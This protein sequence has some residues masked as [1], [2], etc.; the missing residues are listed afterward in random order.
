MSDCIFCKIVK[1]EA[2]SRKV[3]ETEDTYAFF[4]IYPTTRYHTLVIPKKHYTTIF[5]IPE[6]ELR[7]VITSVKKVAKL[8]EEKLGIHNIQ[9]ISN[10]GAVA[11]QEVFHLHFHIVPRKRGDGQNIKWNKDSELV[12]DFEDMLD[13]IK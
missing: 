6:Q 13:K 9:I 4:D 2:K 12:K 5:D 11:Q 10:S 7:S 1:G 3:Y 8:F